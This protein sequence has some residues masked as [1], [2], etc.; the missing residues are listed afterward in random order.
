MRHVNT[1]VNTFKATFTQGV[2][3]FAKYWKAGVAFV[4]PGAALG[5]LAFTPGS[6]GGTAFTWAELG[7]AALTCFVTA[8][9][10]YAAPKNRQ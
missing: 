8:G 2:A 7:T 1:N 10:V 4:A 6:D 5:V 9:A 3:M